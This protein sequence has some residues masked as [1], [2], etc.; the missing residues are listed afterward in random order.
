MFKPF[1]MIQLPGPANTTN[2]ISMGHIT[3]IVA[4]GNKTSIHT[5][6]GGLV[7]TDMAIDQVVG[8]IRQAGGVLLQ[9]LDRSNRTGYLMAYHIGRIQAD[10]KGNATIYYEGGSALTKMSVQDVLQQLAALQA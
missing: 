9:Y 5:I 4:I 10:R 1:P 8:L 6:G 7:S 3:D 2:Y